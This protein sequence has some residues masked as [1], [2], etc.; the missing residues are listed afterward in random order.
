MEPKGE[1]DVENGILKY[2]GVP[3]III[4]RSTQNRLIKEMHNLVG[5]GILMAFRQCGH[6][7]GRNIYREL[8]EITGA[9]GED[10]IDKFYI[11]E[12]DVGWGKYSVPHK[13]EKGC[14]VMVKNGWFAEALKGEVDF[15]VCTYLVGYFEA[16]FSQIYNREVTVK[17]KLC[18]AKGDPYCEFHIEKQ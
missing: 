13:D 3:A 9:K 15:P 18:S 6:E 14:K 17:E 12:E 4:S 8:V 2:N 10:L 7:G 1:I 16:L 5:R 11:I